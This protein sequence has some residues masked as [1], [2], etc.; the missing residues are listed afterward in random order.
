M[1]LAFTFSA[2][3]SHNT[4]PAE[5]LLPSRIMLKLRAWL[6]LL[7]FVH[8]VLHPWVHAMGTAKPASAAVVVSSNLTPSGS[9]LIGGDQCEL[10][11]VGHNATI[12][13]QLPKTAV[14]NPRW[15]RTTLQ[16]V[17][18]ASLQSDRRLPSRAPPNL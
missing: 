10:C 13:P 8:V 14:L 5:F 2:R 11:R 1:G 9:S 18:Y 15:V 6:F 12:T 4:A 16:A 3:L 7:L 17:N